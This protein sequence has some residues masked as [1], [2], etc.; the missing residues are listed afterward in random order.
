MEGTTAR[1]MHFQHTPNWFVSNELDLSRSPNSVSE[2]MNDVNEL[3]SEQEEEVDSSSRE[4]QSGWFLR[5]QDL[6]KIHNVSNCL[7]WKCRIIGNHGALDHTSVSV[8]A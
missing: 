7:V 8:Y 6:K 4:A 3:W 2:N 5:V 1:L